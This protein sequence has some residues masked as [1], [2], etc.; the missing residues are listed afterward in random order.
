MWNKEKI[1]QLL[2]TNDKAVAR[3]V[4]AIYALQTA[5]EKA[6]SDTRHHNNVG[7]N[8][9]DAKRGSYYA[10]YVGRTGR[11][12]GRHLEIARKMMMKYWRQLSEIAN[13]RESYQAV[14]SD[15]G[16]LEELRLA[17]YEIRAMQDAERS[18]QEKRDAYRFARDGEAW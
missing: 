1:H 8:S 14:E 12:T 3:A 6:T 16:N 7:F 11:L 4:S 15:S 13:D 2:S 17:E 5:D 18:E 10:D 9:S